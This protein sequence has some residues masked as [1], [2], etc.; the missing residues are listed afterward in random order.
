MEFTKDF[1][2][3]NSG[4]Y[5]EKKLNCCS[6]MKLEIITLNDI[7]DSEIPLKDKFWFCCK[8]VFNKKMNQ[9][10]A[11]AVAECVLPIYERIFPDNMQP[12]IAIIAAKSYDIDKDYNNLEKIAA[13]DAASDSL[14]VSHAPAAAA[15]AASASYAAAASYAVA[16][17]ASYAADAASY[18]VD[19]ATDYTVDAADYAADAASYAVDA[20]KKDNDENFTN[21]LFKILKDATICY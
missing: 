11:I 8:K 21:S 1:M 4:C 15:A 6:F 10:I 9:A 2:Y 7:V 3:S 16:V 19:A 13:M 20:A 18:S 5:E 14:F 12:R 17:V